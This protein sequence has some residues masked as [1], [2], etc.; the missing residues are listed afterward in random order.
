[1]ETADAVPGAVDEW[2]CAV[3]SRV[4]RAERVT[5]ASAAEATAAI[6]DSGGVDA[7]STLPEA[8]AADESAL[9]AVAA[10]IDALVE[11]VAETDAQPVVSS[12]SAA[13]N[14]ERSD[15]RSASSGDRSDARSSSNGDRSDARSSSNGDRSTDGKPS[16][17]IAR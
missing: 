6:L 8:V 15:A 1:M 4:Q 13:A 7:L 3:E 2:L 17:G 12:L 5:D 16:S 9:R 14:R 11:R 10:R